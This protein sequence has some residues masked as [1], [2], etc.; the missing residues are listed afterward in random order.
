M[1]RIQSIAC[2]RL[3]AVGGGDLDRAVVL[4]VDLG[5]GLLD[6]LAD[7]LAAGADHF[8]DLLLRHVDHGDA[9]RGR[10]HVAAR[11]GQR[12][13][14]LAQDV[15]PPVARLRRARCCMISGVMEVILMSICSR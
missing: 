1:P 15:Q 5:A 10:R 4:D 11:A 8:A 14:H 9:R 13:G 7:H 6:D 3:L 2:L 12:L